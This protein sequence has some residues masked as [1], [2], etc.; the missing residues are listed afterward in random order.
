MC[1]RDRPEGIS[2][3]TVAKGVPAAIL[4]TSIIVIWLPL[5]KLCN[6]ELAGIPGTVAPFASTAVIVDPTKVLGSVPN[7]AAIP[8]RLS[9]VINIVLLPVDVMPSVTAEPPLGKNAD[10][11]L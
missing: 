2:W 9:D 7:V 6:T 8:K 10:S 4:A 1:I 11:L 3:V 5:A